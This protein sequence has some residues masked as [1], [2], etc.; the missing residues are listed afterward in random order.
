MCNNCIHN[1][2]CSRFIA[3]G[4]NVKAC[5]HFIDMN[6]LKMEMM[7]EVASDILFKLHSSLCNR[8]EIELAEELQ[9]VHRRLLLFSAKLE[10][11]NNG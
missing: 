10:S 1:Q 2:V 7:L 6:K 5:E 8:R 9:D 3:T 11:G 4:G